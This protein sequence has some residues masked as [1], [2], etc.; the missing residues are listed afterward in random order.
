MKI[1]RLLQ[2]WLLL[3]LLGCTAT[4]WTP[5]APPETTSDTPLTPAPGDFSEAEAVGRAFLDAWSKDDTARMYELLAP[6]LRAG[7]ALDLLDLR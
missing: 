7:L 6:S 5:A 4:P 1:H 3:C 2:V